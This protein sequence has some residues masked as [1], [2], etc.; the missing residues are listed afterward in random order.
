MDN[1]KLLE[2]LLSQHN[3]LRTDL[4]AIDHELIAETPNLQKIREGIILY[5]HH[6]EGHLET[7]DQTFYPLLLGRLETN[8]LE[9]EKTKTFIEE[10]VLIGEHMKSFFEKYTANESQEINF[11]EFLRDFNNISEELLLRIS[12]EEEGVYTYIPFL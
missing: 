6:L 11:P 10:M 9:M 7:E 12:V 8:K 4:S 1:K 2:L 5:K 3:Q